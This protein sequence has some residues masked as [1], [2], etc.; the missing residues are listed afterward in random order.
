MGGFLG[1]IAALQ[2]NRKPHQTVATNLA[3]EALKMNY[4]LQFI[5]EL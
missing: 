5:G 1:Y 2:I 3:V 4:L